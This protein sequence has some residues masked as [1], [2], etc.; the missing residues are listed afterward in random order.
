MAL[1]SVASRLHLLF[2]LLGLTGLMAV[3]VALVLWSALRENELPWQIGIGGAIAIGLALLFETRGVAALFRSRRTSLGTNVLLQVMLA[4]A[5][6]AGV[7]YFSFQHYKR[8]DWTRAQSFTLPEDV[9]NDLAKLRSDTDIL[10]FQQYVS[11]EQRGDGKQ[12]RYDL[13]AQKKI[14]E[15]VKDLAEMFQDLGPRFRVRILDIQDDDYQEKLK[16]ITSEAP[17]LGEAIVKAPENSIFFWTPDQKKLQRLSFNDIYQLDKTASQ[18][19]VLGDKKGNLIL[20]DPGIQELS[21]KVSRKIFNIEEKRP[22]IGVAVV[23]ELLSVKA[24]DPFYGMP[25]LKKA[26]EA[27]GFDYRDII[28]KK[29]GQTPRPEPAVLTHDENKFERLEAQNANFQRAIKELQEEAKDIVQE[30]QTWEKASLAELNK[31]YAVVQTIQGAALVGWDV[32]ER[33]RKERG[34][35]PPYRKI[36][37][38]DRTLR[39]EGLQDD[40]KANADTLNQVQTKLAKLS[41][42]KSRLNVE[43]LEEQRRITDL[44]AK[45]DR[46]LADIDLLIVPRQT[47]YD[48]VREEAIPASVHVLDDSQVEAIKDFMKS[49]KPVLFCLGPSNER[50]ESFNPDTPRDSLMDVLTSLGLQLPNQTVLFNVEGDAMADK[51]ERALL[52]AS[53]EVPPVKFSW[54]PGSATKNMGKSA[55]THPNPVRSSLNLTARA[56]GK[57]QP[58]E[59][60]LRSPRPVYALTPAWNRDTLLAALGGAAAPLGPFDAAAILL[61]PGNQKVDEGAFIML[62]SEESWNDDQPFPTEKRIPQYERPKPDDPNKGTVQERRRGPF[63]IG[64][65]V[66]A[67]V[68]ASWYEGTPPE[69]LPKVRV[70]VIGHGGVFMGENLKPL[71]EKLFLD[72]AN[73][74]MG[75]DDLLAR[76]NQTWSYP[77]VEISDAENVLWQWGTRLG[78]PLLF[79]YLGLVM[80]LVRQMR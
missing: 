68:P 17:A 26:L 20:N 10:I 2:R 77:R 36:S 70:A 6:L 40:A 61:A 59:L 41:D 63:P 9:K 24:G 74:L 35:L 11:F 12:D 34:G 14:V 4:A 19:F 69:T 47:I 55:T 52:G 44:R 32:M 1:R 62:S 67:T 78:L 76:E 25:G 51:G 50:S 38:R 46:M 23:H 53:A 64:V 42:E 5:L 58:I 15:R 30:Q 18:E 37:E 43:N 49:G 27:R 54:P 66:E 3:I 80:W 45:F 31:K 48:V 73:W 13:A 79:V 71:N 60:Q 28:L 75:R 57:D 16:A 39:L 8:F 72:T 56:F 33:I 29:W 21:R 65:A 7:N 22:R